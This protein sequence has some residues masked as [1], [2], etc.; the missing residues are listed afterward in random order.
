ALTWR[1]TRS[2]TCRRWRFPGGSTV[3][4]PDVPPRRRTLCTAGGPPSRPASTVYAV[5]DTAQQQLDLSR[6]EIGVEPSKGW[7]VTQGRVRLAQPSARACRAAADLLAPAAQAAQ[8][9]PT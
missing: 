6:A 3:R 8:P 5:R 1:G 7:S 4:R 2:T 9:C